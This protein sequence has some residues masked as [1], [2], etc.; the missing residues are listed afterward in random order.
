[1]GDD[2]VDF[3]IPCKVLFD[4]ADGVYFASPSLASEPNLI[5][6]ECDRISFLS[7]QWRA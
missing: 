5:V 4:E 6:Q 7:H 1:M 3:P 2:K